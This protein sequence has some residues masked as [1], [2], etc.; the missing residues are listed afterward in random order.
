MEKLDNLVVKVQQV[1]NKAVITRFVQ[2][3]ATGHRSVL[4]Q[5]HAVVECTTELGLV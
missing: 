4:A 3:G 1:S 2:H 5:K